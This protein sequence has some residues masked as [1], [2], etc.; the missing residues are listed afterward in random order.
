MENLIDYQNSQMHFYVY[1]YTIATVGH[2]IGLLN[3]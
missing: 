3:M 1:F 2:M